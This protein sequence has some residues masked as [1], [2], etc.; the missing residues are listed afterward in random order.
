M[1][2]AFQEPG[3]PEEEA[4]DRILRLQRAIS[5]HRYGIEKDGRLYQIVPHYQEPTIVINEMQASS[6]TGTVASRS[7]SGD[8]ATQRF[9]LESDIRQFR[10]ELG[11]KGTE[12][13]F[14]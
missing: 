4:V 12:E 13:E 8:D 3:G 5:E 10:R 11:R 1:F 6:Q 14:K 2:P 9:L 7:Q